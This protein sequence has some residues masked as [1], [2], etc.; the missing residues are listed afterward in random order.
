MGDVMS[1][2]CETTII[3]SRWVG[4]RFLKTPS[5][6]EMGFDTQIVIP[7]SIAVH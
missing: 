3:F 1:A 7:S 2:L 6:F 5:T 4:P